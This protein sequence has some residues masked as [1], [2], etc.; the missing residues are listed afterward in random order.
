VSENR[1]EEER[2]NDMAVVLDNKDGRTATLYQQDEHLHVCVCVCVYI[3]IYIYI[4]IY[5]RFYF[6]KLRRYV[7]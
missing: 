1:L 3:Y 2:K 7:M 5:T 4:Y 6:E